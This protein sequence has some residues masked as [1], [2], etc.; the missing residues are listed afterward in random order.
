MLSFIL[1]PVLFS[2]GPIEIR[3]YGLVYVLGFV[4]VTFLLLR[5]KKKLSLSKDDVYDLIF[6][7]MLGV[8]IGSRLFHVIF[9]EPSYYLSQP[10]KILF[11]WEGG[12]SFHGGLVGTII[13]CYLFAK[14]KKVSFYKLADFLVVP[15]LV[16]LAFGRIANFING[17][18]VGTVTSVPWCFNFGDDLCRH[19]YQL[20][21]AIKRFALASILFSLQKYYTFREGFIFWLAILLMD[22]GRFSVDF[23]RDEMVYF[24]LTMG[25]W[26][27]LIMIIVSGIVI[28]KYYSKNILLERNL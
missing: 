2:L 15:G 11:I 17:E 4:L 8:L 28:L 20:Y 26:L 18:L 3:Y 22:L 14:K 7:L 19:P 24:N 23:F 13:A 25:Q 5:Y 9:W 16:A 10:W 1:D 27:S 12:M 6:Y 21:S